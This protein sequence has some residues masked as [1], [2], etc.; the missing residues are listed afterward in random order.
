LLSLAKSF[1]FPAYSFHIPALFHGARLLLVHRCSSARK[2]T[3]TRGTGRNVEAG[4][5]TLHLYS[6]SVRIRQL[7]L[8]Q[9]PPP[10][11]LIRRSFFISLE[12]P[13]WCYYDYPQPYKYSQPWTPLFIATHATTNISL[14]TI[15]KYL[16]NFFN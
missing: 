13:S 6:G 1:I 8:T 16:I 10:G 15:N 7:D 12:L 3:S 4:K 9:L 11:R 5:W 14:S 2:Y